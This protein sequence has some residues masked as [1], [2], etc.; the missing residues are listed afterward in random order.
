MTLPATQRALILDQIGQALR[1]DNAYP[2]PQ[3]T[4]GSAIIQILAAGTL[5]Y[6]RD[7]YN[8][9]RKYT[10]PTPSVPGNGAI[11]RV[12][13][14]GPDATSLKEGDLVLVDIFVRARD[15]YGIAA[16]SG[17]HDGHSA[18][19]K[20]MMH[21]EWRDGTYAEYAKMPLEN[22]FV[23]NEERLL[24]SPTSP[25]GVGLGYTVEELLHAATSLVPYGG[26]KDVG[27]GVCETVLVSPATGMFGSAAVHV[28]LAMGANVIAMGRNTDALAKLKADAAAN[29]HQIHTVPIVNDIE[30]ETSAIAKIGLPVD[31]YFDITPHGVT[32]STHT[33]SGIL[34]LRQGGRVSFMGGMGSDISIPINVV[35]QRNLTLKG[36]WMYERK[37]VVRLLQMVESGRLKLEKNGLI[38]R[39]ALEQWKEAFDAAAEQAGPGKLAAIVP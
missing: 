38:G 6:S 20:R 19:A 4:S 5:S 29:G 24:G 21:G 37:D 16:L 13:A 34:S 22:C 31:V 10:L 32:G 25:T 30:Q 15:N 26:L 11:G 23:L 36:K 7:I 35:V 12:V 18:T 1:V 28:A 39:F 2:T 33:R 9:K 17:V 14:L 3:A 8:G 27:L